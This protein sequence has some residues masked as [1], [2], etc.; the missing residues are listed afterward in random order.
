[1]KSGVIMVLTPGRTGSTLLMRIL[2]VLGVNLG[3]TD[4]YKENQEIGRIARRVSDMGTENVRGNDI[5]GVARDWTYTSKPGRAVVQEIR[6]ILNKELAIAPIFA[7]KSPRFFYTM[8]LWK[9][10]IGDIPWSAIIS[11]REREACAQSMFKGWGVYM[12]G[13]RGCRHVYDRALAESAEETRGVRRTSVW[14]EDLLHD[15]KTEMRRVAID[16]DIVWPNEPES[17]EP[18]VSE[19]IDPS[20][21]HF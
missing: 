16:L 19:M 18:S 2:E 11:T 3:S 7:M 21:V 9:Y 8:R 10:A 20:L 15:W 1:M 17:L 14:F 13:I 12:D 4:T 6:D 5:W